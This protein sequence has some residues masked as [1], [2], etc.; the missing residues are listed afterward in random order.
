MKFSPNILF[1]SQKLGGIFFFK[2]VNFITEQLFLVFEVANFAK[3]CPPKK[4]KSFVTQ[5]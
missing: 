3:I 1:F 4:E 5:F 2:T